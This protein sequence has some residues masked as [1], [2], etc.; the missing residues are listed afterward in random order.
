MKALLVINIKDEK[1]L[2]D[3][4]LALTEVRMLDAVVLD[5]RGLR[6]I[7]AEDSPLFSDWLKGTLIR[8]HYYSVILAPVHDMEAMKKLKVVL[9]DLEFSFDDGR[10]GFL[11][12]VPVLGG[13]RGD[14]R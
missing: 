9:D 2:D 1:R 8:Q 5:G 12:L 3:L 13:L 10:D 14:D 4:L 6:R 11:C 7:L